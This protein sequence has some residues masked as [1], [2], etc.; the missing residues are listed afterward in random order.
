MTDF[1][2]LLMIPGAGDELQ[3]IKRGIIEMIDGMVDQQGR[4]RQRTE[5]RASATD[6]ASALRLFPPNVGG[7][8]P[9]V[10]KV[11]SLNARGIVEVWEMILEHRAALGRHGSSRG[12]SASTSARLDA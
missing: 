4:W 12:A 8:A 5:S 1:F 3:G 11:S 2:L 7:W 9:R 10:L 6:Y